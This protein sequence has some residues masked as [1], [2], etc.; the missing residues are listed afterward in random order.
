LEGRRLIEASRAS[1][2]AIQTAPLTWYYHS[3]SN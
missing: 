3:I 2:M 1:T